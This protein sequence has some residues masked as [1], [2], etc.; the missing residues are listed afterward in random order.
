MAL[1]AGAGNPVGSGGTAGTG[2]G[3]NYIG[4]HAFAYS[5]T[6]AIAPNSFTRMLRFN[7]GPQ[8]LSW[9]FSIRRGFYTTRK[10]SD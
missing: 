6:V 10:R 9:D 1:I 7:M 4:E 8:Y 2:T 3:I 5:G